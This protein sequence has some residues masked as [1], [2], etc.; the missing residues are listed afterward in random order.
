MQALIYAEQKYQP[1]IHAKPLILMEK[2][3]NSGNYNYNYAQS[4]FG[5]DLEKLYIKLIR[6][7]ERRTY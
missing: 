6:K 4:F 7:E 2:M 1:L 3:I 5:K